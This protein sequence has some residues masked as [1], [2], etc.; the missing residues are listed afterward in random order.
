MAVFFCG[1]AAARLVER[2]CFGVL[3]ADASASITALP[4]ADGCAV[5]L[6]RAL[7]FDHNIKVVGLVF[8]GALDDGKGL[9]ASVRG[10]NAVGRADK[11]GTVGGSESREDEA[12]R[13]GCC[14][15]DRQ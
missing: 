5:L 9:G 2:G 10:S 7:G 6:G 14:A 1:V 3:E 11:D 8:Q 4:D 12:K 15:A 13:G